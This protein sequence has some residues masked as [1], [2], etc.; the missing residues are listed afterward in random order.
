MAQAMKIKKNK[1]GFTLIEIIISL[2]LIGFVTTIMSMGFVKIFEGYLLTKD[3]AN[4]TMKAQLVLTRLMKEFS[5]IDGVSSGSGTSMTYSYILGGT[6]MTNRTVSWSGTV[7]DPL[8]LGN[9]ILSENVNNF[10][11]NYCTSYSDAGD[12]IWNGT[13]K[14]IRITLK[15]TGA[16]D[17][18]STFSIKIAPRNL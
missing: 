4:T 9:N 6:T 13:E 5:S 11:L 14:I 7:N 15:L 3:N 10:E 2:V 18:V 12:N 8:M 1:Q 17:V 16:M